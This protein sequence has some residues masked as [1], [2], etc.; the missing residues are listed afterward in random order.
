MARPGSACS[1]RSRLCRQHTGCRGEHT[2][3]VPG[4]E[5][6]GSMTWRQAGLSGHGLRPAR[7][8]TAWLARCSARW[9]AASTGGAAGGPKKTGGRQASVAWFSG[10]EP[11]GGAPG[12]EP[13][14]GAQAPH[15]SRPSACPGS[16]RPGYTLVRLGTSP[17][18]L[19]ESGEL[20]QVG[21]GRA[22]AAATRSSAPTRWGAASSSCGGTQPG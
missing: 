21:G 3:V 6:G 10:L 13:A 8:F 14:L 12:W 19:V 18:P 9:G 4:C 1:Q 16:G 11:D 17:S 2:G 20:P 22:P 15:D 5:A 7:A